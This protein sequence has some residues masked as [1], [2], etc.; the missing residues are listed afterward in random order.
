MYDPHVNSMQTRTRMASGSRLNAPRS[1][2][3]VSTFPVPEVSEIVRAKGSQLNKAKDTLMRAFGAEW[4]TAN[5]EGKVL[6]KPQMEGRMDD[7]R[8]E[9]RI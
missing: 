6:S 1:K 3:K 5:I 8:S 2:R 4:R 7:R 9:P